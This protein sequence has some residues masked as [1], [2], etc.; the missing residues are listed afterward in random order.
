MTTIDLVYFDAGGGH[1]AAACALRASLAV[2]RPHW[3]VRL[4]HLFE[5]LDPQQRFRQVTGMA[6]EQYYNARLARGW[7]LGLAQEL[8]VLQGMI[9]LAQGRLVKTLS[10][11]WLRTEPDLVVSLVPNFNGVLHRSLAA[12]LPG[13]P[14]VTV[15]TDLADFPPNFWI[16]TEQVQ[17]LICGS[18]HATQQALAAGHAADRVHTVSGMLLRPD[19]Y[20]LPV[21]DRPAARQRWG[22]HPDRPTG[23]VMFGG[24]G[25]STMLKIAAALPDTQLIFLCGHNTGLADRL[26]A[27]PAGAPR[28]VVGFTADV[29]HYM[30]LADFFIGKPGPGSLSEAVH[31]CLPVIVVAN[32]WT[33][34][35][36]RYNARWVRDNGL[37]LV[38]TSFKHIAPA[39][40]QLVDHLATYT[41]ATMRLNNRAAFEIV[42][43]LDHILAR[44]QQV[45]Q[46]QPEQPVRPATE[47]A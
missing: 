34:P 8:K 25:A 3:R 7:T 35:Q 21:I 44:S 13:V 5:V 17:D 40:R 46:A 36:E 6:P 10:D 15:L 26:R 28:L 39:V 41:M 14:F 47:P 18:P 32:A 1:R 29:P 30:Q 19:F 23:L 12:T 11:H 4:V 16:E 2:Q 27:M 24:Q 43:Q 42:D 20:N 45:Q 33:M 38:L 22:L 9:R 37:G 31:L